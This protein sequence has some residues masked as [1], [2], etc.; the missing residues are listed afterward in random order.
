[1]QSTPS[2]IAPPSAADHR[3]DSPGNPGSMP[4]WDGICRELRLDGKLLKKFRQPADN[5]ERILAAFQEE[6]WPAYIFNPLPP[7]PGQD[8]TSRLHAA[9]RRLNRCQK[10]PLIRFH[11]ENNGEAIRWERIA[12]PSPS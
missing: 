2:I 6:G 9:V 8:D 4:H 5:Q 1:M 11:V 7:R 12:P 3:S 10:T